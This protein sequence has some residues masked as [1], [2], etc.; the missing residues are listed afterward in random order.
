MRS[1]LP[2]LAPRTESVR[3][4]AVC[5]AFI[6]IFVLAFVNADASAA[7]LNGT[8]FSNPETGLYDLYLPQAIDEDGGDSVDDNLD[9]TSSCPTTSTAQ[10]AKLS[11]I[12]LSTDRPPEVHADLNLGLR[13]YVTVTAALDLVN[14]NGDT[15]W[16]APQLSSVVGEGRRPF[17]A[18]YQVNDWNWACTGDADELW[19]GHG[20]RAEPIPY[21]YVTLIALETTESE[22]I[23]VP[24]RQQVIDYSGHNA[25]VLYAEEQRI[26]LAFTREDTAAIGYV[27]HIEDI[28]VDPSLLALYRE[29]DDAGRRYLPA[30]SSYEQLGTGYVS[31]AKLAIRDSGSFMDPRSRKDW[32]RDH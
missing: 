1:H 29:L 26:T 30:L 27:L 21:P 20:C 15:D 22:A 7:P 19:Y 17:V 31:S 23:R 9:G 28:C 8:I 11:V 4:A 12:G 5:A 3:L 32:W 18:A 13:S 6:T 2:N 25:L 14:I 24:Y 16:D 10:F